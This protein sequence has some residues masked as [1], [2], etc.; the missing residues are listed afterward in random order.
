MIDTETV[1]GATAL[2]EFA[3]ATRIGR[4]R[5]VNEDA[6]GAVEQADVFAVVD[7]CG[8]VAPG[9]LAAKL[10]I[11]ALRRGFTGVAP[12]GPQ[13]EPLAAAVHLANRTIIDEVGARWPRSGIGCT[14]AALRLGPERDVVVHVGDCRIYRMRDGK[15]ERLTLDHDLAQIGLRQGC[16]LAAVQEVM[17]T[18]STVV[19][20]SLGF[21]TDLEL[22]VRYLAGRPGD[23]YLLCSDGITRQLA[24]ADIAGVLAATDGLA[25]GV[26]RLLDMADDRGGSDNETALLVRRL[27]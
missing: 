15:L 3:G 7:G 20:A 6:L 23:L 16:D 11:E 22:D 13:A 4:R 26:E 24:D 17:R 25:A 5:L 8:G 14:L 18:H 12:A 27:A 1:R 21:A 9:D 2:A 10:A 19:T